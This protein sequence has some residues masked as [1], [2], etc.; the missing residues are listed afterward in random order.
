MSASTSARD[1][2]LEDLAVGDEFR[3]SE[4]HMD[5]DQIISFASQFDP[6]PFHI[7]AEA[8]K[9]SFFGGLAASGWHTAA[10]AMRLIVESVPLADGVIG[11]GVEVTWSSPVRPGDTLHVVS[12]V[13]EI[14]PSR[15][16]PNQAIL[17]VES[18][19]LNQVGLL[20]QTTVSKLLAFR[21]R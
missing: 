18:R 15:S 12:V 1:L 3:S 19:M 11:A 14:L 17:T 9:Q 7:D 10:L 21:R 13:R 8:A 4:H 16:K 6:Q 2:Y 20:K 5:A